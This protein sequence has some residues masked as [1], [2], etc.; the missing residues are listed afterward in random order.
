MAVIA[1]LVSSLDGRLTKGTDSNVTWSSMEDKDHFKKIKAN[2]KAII[3]GSTTYEVGKNGLHSDQRVIVHTRTPE[4][5]FTDNP[6]ITFT[7][8]KPQEV[9]K[10]LQDEGFQDIFVLGGGK[11][12]S[13]YLEDNVLNEIWITIEPKLFGNGVNFY[14]TPSVQER[15]LEL[16]ELT[17]LN[18]NTILLKYKFS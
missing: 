15:N 17:K 11:I 3:Y 14:E 7:K 2:A 10:M 9:V 6:K 5:Y 18:N 16:K 1:V 13:M 12:Y 4:K 8:A